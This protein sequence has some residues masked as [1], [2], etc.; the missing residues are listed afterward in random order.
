[1]S[2]RMVQLCDR[3]GELLAVHE[4]AC[5][6][7]DENELESVW[8]ETPVE[9]N[10]DC[11]DLGGGEECLDEVGGV[12]GQKPDAIAGSDAGCGKSLGDLIG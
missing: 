7:I 6:G 1:M 2:P 3:R 11:S 9:W 5:A 8:G 10:G 12:H 4:D